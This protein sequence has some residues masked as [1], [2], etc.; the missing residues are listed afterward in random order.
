MKIT[1]RQWAII[2]VALG[3]VA[4]LV[5]ALMPRPVP[6]EV[7]RVDRGPLRVTVD[8]DG[9]TRIR[10]RHVISAPLA[11]ELRRIELE[12]GDSV[13]AGRTLVATIEPNP[14]ELIDARTR[15]LLEARLRTAETQ[16][17][18]A[19][20]RIE[21]ARAAQSLAGLEFQRV[22]ALARENAVAPQEVDRAREAARM[23]AEDVKSAEYARQIA[24]FELEQAQAAMARVE[25]RRP[26]DCAW[27]M[28]IVSPVDG[29]VLRVFHE[30]AAV[31]PA[32]ARLIEIGDPADLEIEIDVLSMDAVRVVPG[33]TVW[34]EHWG[35]P[36]PLEARVRLVEPAGF[37][38]ISALGVEEQR[39]NVIADFVSPPDQRRTLGDAYRIEARIV[40]WQADDVLKA[41]VGALFRS[42]GE[43]SVFLVR[44]GRA[45][46]TRVE[47]GHGD[48]REMEIL[49]GLQRGDAVVLHP[50]DKV[51]DAVAVR[52]RNERR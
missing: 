29:R 33:A 39:V 42:G 8:E 30:D 49:N 48:G 14:P 44:E 19:H 52:I 16:L 37:L 22:Q 38:K 1:R 51:A 21:R 41:P 4:V 10:E 50:S 24:G 36:K 32:G 2:G 27:E 23:A 45:R 25:P 11:G 34:V 47:V 5:Y 3:F 28:R 18:L 26:D 17:R 12:P 15:R 35:G 31:V 43:W 6:V 46:L 7:A 9:R 20:P 40:V 13:V